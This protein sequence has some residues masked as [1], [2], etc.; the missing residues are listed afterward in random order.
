MPRFGEGQVTTYVILGM[1]EDPE[2][3]VEGCRRAVD[4]GVYPFVVPLRPVA[5]SL[6]ADWSPPPHDYV[7]RIVRRVT[8][9]LTERRPRRG[10]RR[11]RAARAATPAHP[12]PRCRTRLQIGRKP[13][14]RA[15]ADLLHR[16]GVVCR[17]VDD[18]WSGRRAPPHPHRRCS[19]TSRACSR[20]PTGTAATTSRPRIKVLG[21]RETSPG[22][23]CASTPSTDTGLW[24]GDRL[25]V[26]AGT[27]GTAS[28]RPLVRFA[29]A[30]AAGRG[31]HRMAAHIQPA[32]R[33]LLRAP[34]L[35]R[36]R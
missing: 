11:R 3:T 2:L 34:R 32:Q 6:M 26:L 14:R 4:V 35:A 28:V 29:V 25:A 31:G 20:P 7:E 9:Y 15:V 30:T 19:S 21:L 23:P 13:V 12:W 33:R 8:P 27:G 22:A 5:G 10:A 18:A 1:G 16:T 17:L 24:Q 36:R